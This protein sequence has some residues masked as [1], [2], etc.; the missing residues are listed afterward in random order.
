MLQFMTPGHVSIYGTHYKPTQD[1]RQVENMK[2]FLV[3]LT[4]Q[5]LFERVPTKNNRH[6]KITKVLQPKQKRCKEEKTSLPPTSTTYYTL[7]YILQ[8]SKNHY[9]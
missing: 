6:R 2:N 4:R 8:G 5:P 7:K 3:V 9:S 1:Q